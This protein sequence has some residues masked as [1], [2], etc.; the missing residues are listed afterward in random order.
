MSI[1]KK[2]VVE[3]T[4]PILMLEDHELRLRYI[5]TYI[6]EGRLDHANKDS[7][8]DKKNNKK[9]L[10]EKVTPISILEDHE[11][12]L[13]NIELFINNSRKEDEASDDSNYDIDNNNTREKKHHKQPP[14]VNRESNSR[15]SNSRET[16]SRETK[17]IAQS[18][19]STVPLVEK[20]STLSY[21]KERRT[22]VSEMVDSEEPN[23]VKK[24]ITMILSRIGELLTQM[25]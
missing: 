20:P 11:L 21:K 14:L 13:R 17:A 1:I 16:N 23:N 7:F 10:L 15:E 12:R 6:R 3:Q 22:V 25:R 5:E 4:T 9:K 8:L 19:P 18:P 2:K 24:E